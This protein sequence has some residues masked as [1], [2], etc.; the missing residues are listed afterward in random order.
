MRQKYA[1]CA[2]IQPHW[3]ISAWNTQF[4]ATFAERDAMAV[5]SLADIKR[6][7]MNAAKFFVNSDEL[8][9]WRLRHNGPNNAD[10]RAALVAEKRHSQNT[11]GA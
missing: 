6:D 4:K 1:K 8:L 11:P 3:K 9:T 7:G 5:E 2:I 10:S